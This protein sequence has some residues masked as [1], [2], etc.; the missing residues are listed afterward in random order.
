MA[1]IDLTW[2]D[3]SSTETGFEV[4]RS[5]NG[6][7]GWALIA[8][9][10]ANAVG[11]SD[12]G[13]DPSTTYYYRVRAKRGSERSSYTN[14]ASA[15]TPAGGCAVATN[16]LFHYD[17][18]VQAQSDGAAISA[19]TDLSP[20]GWNLSQA[21]SARR[22]KFR[23]A[24]QNGLGV[25]EA[26]VNT[27]MSIASLT[28]Q[29]NNYTFHFVVNYRGNQDGDAPLL[30]NQSGGGGMQLLASTESGE[31]VTAFSSGTT[32]DAGFASL[33]GWQVLS[34]VF[35]DST[36]NIKIYRNGTLIGTIAYTNVTD[37][38]SV[39]LIG[40]YGAGLDNFVGYIGEIICNTDAHDGTQVTTTASCLMTKWGI[41]AF[42]PYSLANQYWMFETDLVFPQQTDN[43]NFFGWEDVSPYNDGIGFSTGAKFRTARFGS[44]PA[45]QLL[46]GNDGGK[47]GVNGTIDSAASMTAYFVLDYQIA[48]QNHDFVNAGVL[49]NDFSGGAFHTVTPLVGSDRV[50]TDQ[51]SFMEDDTTTTHDFVADTNGKKL[52][53]FKFN[54]AD[55]TAKLYR[56]GT[57]VGTVSGLGTGGWYVDTTAFYLF[58]TNTAGAFIGY[59][60]AGFFFGA[61][62]NDTDRGNV[63]SYLMTKYGIS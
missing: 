13:L 59:C 30:D 27:F 37:T 33:S 48:D 10:A 19:V 39:W 58:N 6:N 28:H 53:T 24:W 47:V 26:D 31:T 5:P 44:L 54:K 57:L 42:N 4:E 3:N 34:W 46:A 14:V 60:P 29:R 63:E 18:S 22:W 8:S 40:S 51:V 49:F 35:S 1:Q 12:A 55:G 32:F 36:N 52:L 41:A 45:A 62:H 38:D 17:L 61:A 2:K 7:T 23:T 15:T 50:G 21:T 20:N 43:T 9:P 56:N 25:A 16:L 11:Y